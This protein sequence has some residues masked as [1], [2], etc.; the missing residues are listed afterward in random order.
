MRNHR[1]PDHNFRTLGL[2]NFSPPNDRARTRMPDG[3]GGVGRQTF[4]SR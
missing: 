4:L 3:V 2:C 1:L